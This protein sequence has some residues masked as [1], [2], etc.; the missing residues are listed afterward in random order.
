MKTRALAVA[1]TC[2]ILGMALLAIM[3]AAAQQTVPDLLHLVEPGDTW[4]ALAWRFGVDEQTLRAANP[5]PNAQAQPAIGQTIVIPGPSERERLG[6]VVNSDHGGL[7]QLSAAARANPWALVLVNGLSNPYRPLL[8]R[9]ILLPDGTNPPKQFPP[10]ISQLE[11]SR[12]PAL[13]GQALAI[14]GLGQPDGLSVA[15]FAGGDMIVSSSGRHFVA[16]SASGAFFEPGQYPLE[17][18]V[19]GEPLWTQPWLVAPGQ[20][21]FEEITYTGQAATIDSETIRQEGERLAAIWSQVTDQAN[22]SS[23]FTEPLQDYLGYSS[24][25]GARRSY[26]GGPYN[27][28]H[29]GLDFSA[30]GGTAVYAPA[31]G[32]VV[33]AER[34]AARGGAVII[35]HGLGVFSGYYHLSEVLAEAD[36][37]VAAGD[38]IGRVGS[39]GL[40]T[41]NHL[42]WDLLV[43]GT[44]VNPAAWREDHMACWLLEGL[45]TPCEAP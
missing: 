16:L 45:G 11:V 8:Y 20:W 38:L 1:L 9:S 10:G 42:H 18:A 28:Y 29:E 30:Y 22:W 44:W 43:G 21:T 4:M 3:P 6:V 39:S 12:A 35:D 37:T 41:G 27:R 23:D 32:N 40:S 7:L 19:P 34:L 25:Y 13:P 17:V 5:H 33:L 31:A 2:A 15:R 24:L 14:R 36:Q 26:G